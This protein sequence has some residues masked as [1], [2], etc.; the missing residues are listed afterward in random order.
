MLASGDLAYISNQIHVF[1]HDWNF[2]SSFLGEP[3]LIGDLLAYFDGRVLYV[4]AFSL[5]DVWREVALEEIQ[6]IV[7][8]PEF[9]DVEAI[10][11]WGRFAPIAEFYGSRRFPC[12]AYHDYDKD[13][14]DT[15]IDL[16]T[17]EWSLEPA[18]R[19]ARASADNKAIETRVLQRSYLLAGH[20][21]LIEYWRATHDLSPV[22]SAIAASLPYVIQKSH[23]YLVEASR[24]GELLGFAALSFPGKTASILLQSYGYRRPGGR[25]GDAIMGQAIA[26]AKDLGSLRLHLGYSRTASLLAFKRKW[27]G[28]LD[29]P[30]YREAFFSD[31]SELRSLVV[32]ARYLWWQRLV[33]GGRDDG[34]GT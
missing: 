17:F 25:V 21:S 23:I 13:V 22:H 26:F 7:A 28:R 12:I 19:Q 4:C 32:D 1:D 6:A 29:G 15:A 14:F 20:I 27:A 3:Y 10:N 31:S 11:V 24:L 5:S 2:Y 9:V 18:A 34:P 30:P 33:A 16:S 8:R